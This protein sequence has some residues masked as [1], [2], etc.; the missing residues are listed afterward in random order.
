MRSAHYLRGGVVV[1]RGGTSYVPSAGLTIAAD[2]NVTIGHH[3]QLAGAGCDQLSFDCG[4]GASLTLSGLL[5]VGA[6]LR[7]TGSPASL[8]LDH[9]TLVPGYAGARR[10]RRPDGRQ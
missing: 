7:I 10:A 4:D 9:C 3:R 8:T 6:A 5:I 1:L 2:A